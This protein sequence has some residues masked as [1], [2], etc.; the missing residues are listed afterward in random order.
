MDAVS[1]VMLQR[2]WL[3][4]DD[5]LFTVCLGMC[6]GEGARLNVFRNP[7]IVNEIKATDVCNKSNIHCEIFS[8]Y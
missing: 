4:V 3:Q 7:Y 8:H 1:V 6:R 5:V 2:S